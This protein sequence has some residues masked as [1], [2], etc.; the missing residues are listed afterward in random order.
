M[1]SLHSKDALNDV[2]DS[3]CFLHPTDGG[4]T[5]RDEGH[6]CAR[7]TH[8]EQSK[9]NEVAV[10]VTLLVLMVGIIGGVWFYMSKGARQ[11]SSGNYSQ[12]SIQAD[13]RD[14]DD[15]NPFDGSLSNIVAEPESE[16]EEPDAFGAAVGFT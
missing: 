3:A 14:D 12:L 4:R 8:L 7:E 11:G 9:H 13:D 2:V 1:T 15:E 10:V 6:R 5:R 16:P